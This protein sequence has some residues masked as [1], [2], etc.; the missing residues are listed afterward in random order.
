MKGKLNKWMRI[1]LECII[2]GGN[3][4]FQSLKMSFEVLTCPKQSFQLCFSAFI[5]TTYRRLEL[6]MITFHNLVSRMI[7]FER[8]NEI[9]FNNF[10]CFCCR[11]TV[12][13]L[14]S[15]RNTGRRISLTCRCDLWA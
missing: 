14:D 10:S 3:Y 4:F 6:T 12:L 5:L 7:I 9:T 2:I 1:L 15:M 8:L 11:F 13:L